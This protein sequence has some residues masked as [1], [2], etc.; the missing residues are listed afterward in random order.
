MPTYDKSL[1]MGPY[2]I[3]RPHSTFIWISCFVFLNRVK[4]DLAGEIDNV[5]MD[6]D[7]TASRIS[8]VQPTDARPPPCFKWWSKSKKYQD[9]Y[10]EQEINDEQEGDLYKMLPLVAKV[11]ATAPTSPPTIPPTIPA[12]AILLSIIRQL[13]FPLKLRLET[14]PLALLKLSQVC[15]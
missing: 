12:I 5:P 7:S 4:P 13:L 2:R 3:F 10:Q 14:F 11:T 15:C 6:K 9:K 8:C 1:S